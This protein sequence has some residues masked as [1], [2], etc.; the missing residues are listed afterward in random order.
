MSAIF[1]ALPG[2]EAPVGSISKSLGEMWSDTAAKG[3]DAPA[4]EDAKATQ[5]NFVLH[6]GFA[7]MPEDAARQFQTAV[8]FS[9]RDPCR[10]VVLCPLP[11]DSPE[12]EMRAKVYGE[13]TLGKSKGD[14]RCC[15]FVM[16]SYPRCTRKYR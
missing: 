2:L 8:S 10:V 1:D 12:T 13:C 6:L 14:T 16:L 11:D 5:V 3:G 4:S 9:R 7:T 15:E